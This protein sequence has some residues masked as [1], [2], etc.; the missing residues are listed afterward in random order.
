MVS[1]RLAAKGAIIDVN[2]DFFQHVN[3]QE[4]PT[5]RLV[6]GLCKRA[7]DAV[8]EASLQGIEDCP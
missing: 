4:N 6:L 7:G 8:G 3:S 5:S 2:G 1:K